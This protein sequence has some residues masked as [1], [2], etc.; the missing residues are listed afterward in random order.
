M[1]KKFLICLEKKLGV[2]QKTLVVQSTMPIDP[3]T[4]IFLI[5]AQMFSNN[6]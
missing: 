3:I 5:I 4:K 1:T 6:A 2:T